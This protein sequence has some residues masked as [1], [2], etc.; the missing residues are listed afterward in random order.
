MKYL[1]FFEYK[2]E[3][4]ERMRELWKQVLDERAKGS[5][6]WPKA[7]LFESHAL[8]AE[9]Y[10]KSLDRQGFFIFETDKE[11]QITNYRM[12]FANIMDINFIPITSARRTFESWMGLK[13]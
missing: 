8:Q 10:K 1:A 12:H 11:E 3:D 2:W 6:R 7:L 13:R 5:D 4:V 9:L